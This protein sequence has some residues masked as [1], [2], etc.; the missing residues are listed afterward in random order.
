MPGALRLSMRAG[1]AVVFNPAGLHRGRYQPAIPR[2]TLL[3]TYTARSGAVHDRFVYQPWLRDCEW[4]SRLSPRAHALVDEFLD[5][6]R[7]DLDRQLV[8]SYD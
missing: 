5:V 6:F 7:D 1:D 8:P 2:R 3:F 4:T